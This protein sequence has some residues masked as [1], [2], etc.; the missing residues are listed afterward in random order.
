MVTPDIDYKI[1]EIIDS[2]DG[3]CNEFHKA[4][5]ENVWYW[6]QEARSKPIEEVIEAFKNAMEEAYSGGR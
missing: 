5:E 4:E 1:D 3:T 6:L 2:L